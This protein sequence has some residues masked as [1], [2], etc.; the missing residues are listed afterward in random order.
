MSVI[1][2]R[3]NTKVGT[4][5]VR[6]Q[7][8]EIALTPDGKRAYLSSRGTESSAVLVLDIDDGTRAEDHLGRA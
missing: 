1:D 3:I 6:V 5:N 4:T 7:L 2:T 8:F